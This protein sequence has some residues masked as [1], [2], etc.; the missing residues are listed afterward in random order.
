MSKRGIAVTAGGLAATLGQAGAEAA[1][2]PAVLTGSLVK[3]GLAGVGGAPVGGA[4]GGGLLGKSVAVFQG[5]GAAGKA[6][7]VAT[8]AAGGIGVGAAVNEATQPDPEPATTVAVSSLWVD[9]PPLDRTGTPGPE[10]LDGTWRV[11]EAYTHSMPVERLTLE[12]DTLRSAISIPGVPGEPYELVMRIVEN[13]QQAQ[14]AVM[15]LDVLRCNYPEPNPWRALV[16]QRIEAIYRVEGDVLTALASA[17]GV[18]RPAG[19]EQSD[20]RPIIG[21]HGFLDPEADQSR[22]TMQAGLNPELAGQWRY[23]PYV[24][25]TFEEG[26]GT[27]WDPFDAINFHEQFEMIT[28]TPQAHPDGRFLLDTVITQ[29]DQRALVGRRLPVLMRFEGPDTLWVTNFEGPALLTGRVPQ[30]FD[31]EKEMWQV[32]GKLKRIR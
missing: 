26:R 23:L 2:V 24:Y 6:A 17:D 3:V 10:W 13:D 21:W 8:A 25:L 5:M 28:S 4:A 15:V 22:F 31:Y 7:V 20:G 14:P 18:G 32:L 29:N 27:A 9:S 30:H 12:G 19:F 11:V 16:G 1:A